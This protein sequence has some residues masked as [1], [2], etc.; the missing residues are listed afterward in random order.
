MLGDRVQQSSGETACVLTTPVESTAQ[1]YS[2]P[3]KLRNESPPYSDEAAAP[4]LVP[5]Q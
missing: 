4:V 5:M 3:L 1:W 2:V